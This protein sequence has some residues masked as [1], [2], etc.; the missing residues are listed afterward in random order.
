MAEVLG[1]DQTV[2]LLMPTVLGMAGDP[3]A[4]VRF[5][6]AKTL[7]KICP[8]INDHVYVLISGFGFCVKLLCIKLI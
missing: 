2:K 5:N 6:V 8:V 3:V 4:N 1:P 7:Q